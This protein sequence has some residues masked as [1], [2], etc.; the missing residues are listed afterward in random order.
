MGWITVADLKAHLNVTTD[1][2]DALL[3]DKIAAAEAWIAA[4]T[5]ADIDADAV[6]EPLK[7]AARQLA[8]HLYENREASLVGITAQELPFGLIDL[9]APYREWAF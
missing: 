4:C 2:D 8:G 1:T 5:G 6:P 3:T 7:E 9:V